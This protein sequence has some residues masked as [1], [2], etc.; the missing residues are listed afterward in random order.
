LLGEQLGEAAGL[1]Q[2]LVVVA[3]LHDVALVEDVDA[4][5]VTKL[6]RDAR[7]GVAHAIRDPLL[8]QDAGKSYYVLEI[9]IMFVSLVLMARI[10]V[11]AEVQR[12]GELSALSFGPDLPV[13]EVVGSETVW[14]QGTAM[15]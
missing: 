13:T 14:C 8:P 1:L 2:Q 11:P 15:S 7:D 10:G 5:H 6:V 4:V 9:N 3:L 12:T